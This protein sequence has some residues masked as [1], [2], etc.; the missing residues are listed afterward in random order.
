ML[1]KRKF[2][3]GLL[4]GPVFLKLETMIAENARV[5]PSIQEIGTF[6]VS[7]FQKFLETFN[8]SFCGPYKTIC[9]LGNSRPKIVYYVSSMNHCDSIANGGFPLYGRYEFKARAL[10]KTCEESALQF[11]STLEFPPFWLSMIPPIFNESLGHYKQHF[12]GF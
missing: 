8:I 2:I 12:I 6:D 3:Q 9:P 10:N 5:F 7:K 1:Q 11:I 4:W